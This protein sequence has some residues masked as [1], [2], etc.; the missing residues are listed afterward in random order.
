MTRPEKFI[1]RVAGPLF[2]LAALLEGLSRH[3]DQP[4]LHVAAAWVLITALFVVLTPIA[5]ATV[6]VAFQSLLARRRS[7]D[8]DAG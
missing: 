4:A 7:R 2:I 5:V 3:A 8:S 6:L 1:L